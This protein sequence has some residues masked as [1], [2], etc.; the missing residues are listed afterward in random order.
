M[1]VFRDP[2]PVSD[3]FTF[4]RV[5][6]TLGSATIL[7]GIELRV[8]ARGISV[9]SGRSGSGKS[10]LTRLCNRLLD[11]SEGVVRHRGQDVRSL[12]VLAL[13]RAVGMVF[14]RSTL[15]DGTVRDN[16]AVTG[17]NE[18]RQHI[19]ILDSVGLG[20]A[21]LDRDASTLSG[22]ESQ[23]ICLA[24]TLLMRPQV[25]VADEPTAALDETSA[26]YLEELACRLASDG[27]P[28]LWV[29]HDLAQAERISDHHVILEEGRVAAPR[30]SQ[31]SV[32]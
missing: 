15:F 25:V 18:P 30:S 21:F 29:T 10:T 1:R 20:S 32:R 3:V 11:A 6:V 7:D 24:R 5:S 19:A 22:G 13:R 17:V 26:R 27:V 16:L 2:T 23:R 14:Q 31:P 9:V 8:P 4:E 28:I 12:D